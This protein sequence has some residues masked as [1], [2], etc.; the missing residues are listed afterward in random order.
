MVPKRNAKTRPGAAA[1]NFAAVIDPA[2]L[3]V[4]S[5]PIRIEIMR[6]LIMEGA[7]DIE[8]IAQRFPQDRSVISRHLGILKSARLV[9]SEKI[10]R[11]VRYS[12]EAS[13]L[14]QRI[15]LMAAK[16]RAVLEACCP[17]KLQKKH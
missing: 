6:I 12:V 7:N 14:L 10:G 5:E 1:T 4:L 3:K 16:A 8:T 9:N 2:F 11:K 15:E 13:S 17:E